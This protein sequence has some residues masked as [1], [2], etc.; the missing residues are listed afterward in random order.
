MIEWSETHIA[1]RDA[2]RRFVEAE[3]KPNLAELEHG[4]TPGGAPCE[5]IRAAH[6]WMAPPRPCSR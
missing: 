6:G 3:I 5:G 2:F 1:I 4:D